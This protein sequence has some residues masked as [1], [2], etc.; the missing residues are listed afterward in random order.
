MSTLML[1]RCAGVLCAL[2]LTLGAIGGCGGDD[3]DNSGAT[4]PTSPADSTTSPAAE[5]FAGDWQTTFG[6]LQLE[7]TNDG[8]AGTYAFCD[9]KLTGVARGNRLE[10]TWEED[11]SACDDPRS[12]A[13]KV[14]EGTFSFTLDEPGNAF[15]GYYETT[16]SDQRKPWNGSRI[17]P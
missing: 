7:E 3:S 9:G 15:T 12:A 5:N 1:T 11:T 16:G 14:A 17:V 2:A 8:V 4:S 10:G 6:K 13:R